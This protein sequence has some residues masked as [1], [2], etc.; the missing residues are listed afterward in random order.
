[1]RTCPE[2]EEKGASEA[3]EEVEMDKLGQGVPGGLR[4]YSLFES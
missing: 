2:N 1:M 3:L 4:D